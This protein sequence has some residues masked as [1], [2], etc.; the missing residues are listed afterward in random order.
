MLMSGFGDKSVLNASVFVLRHLW[1]PKHGVGTQSCRFRRYRV[2]Q[3][4]LN[5][6]SKIF[7][8]E[9]EWKRDRKFLNESTWWEKFNYVPFLDHDLW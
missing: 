8:Q 9:N 1:I 5:R 2:S 3:L 4:L 6:F 7:G